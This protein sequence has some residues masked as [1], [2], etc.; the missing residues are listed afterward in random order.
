[1]L[2]LFLLHPNLFTNVIDSTFKLYQNL[3]TSH[4]I[5]FYGSPSF[6]LAYFNDVLTR[7]HVVAHA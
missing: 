4:H 3:P 2:F 6:W 5:F 7:L 1:M